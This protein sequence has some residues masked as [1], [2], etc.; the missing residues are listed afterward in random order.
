MASEEDLDARECVY[1]EDVGDPRA[2]GEEQEADEALEAPALAEALSLPLRDR[3]ALVRKIGEGAFGEVHEGLDRVTSLTVA[4]KLAR[5]CGVPGNERDDGKSV[6]KAVL[7]ELWCLREL[8]GVAHVS[9][10]L[11][12]FPR[13]SSL[14]M[15][16]A[17]CATDLKA[18]MDE[19]EARAPLAPAVAR[20]W[21]RHLLEGLGAVHGA[22][23]MHRDVKPSNCLLTDGGVLQLGDFGQ[24]RP[25]DRTTDD[26]DYSHQ[27]STRWY[28]AP[29]I[30]FGARKYGAAV[31]LWAVGVVLAEALHNFVLFEGH[32][33]IEQLVTVFKKMGSPSPERWPSARALPDFPKIC[34]PDMDPQPF[35]A[36]LPRADPDALDALAHLLV[37][38]PSGRDGARA[39]LTRPFFASAADAPRVDLATIVAETA[40]RVAAKPPPRSPWGGPDDDSW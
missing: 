5:L 34:F 18:V 37:L 24:A 31:D 15:V 17:F 16:L 13:G 19:R 3:F 39:A 1:A 4:V 28:R 23:L 40:A 6:P 27:V 7:R 36:F 12:H 26:P 9:Q 10:Y 2:L 35:A 20:A 30:L 29:E 33:D 8:V 22:G 21:A 32:S 38:E 14:A 25:L 11:A